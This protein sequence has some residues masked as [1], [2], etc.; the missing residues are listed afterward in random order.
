MHWKPAL[1]A[2]SYLIVD[3]LLVVNRVSKPPHS[4]NMKPIFTEARMIFLV[5]IDLCSKVCAKC[6]LVCQKNRNFAT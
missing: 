4:A 6:A 3:Q 2:A 5:K 1:A